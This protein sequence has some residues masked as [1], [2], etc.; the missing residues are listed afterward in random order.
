MGIFGK[1]RRPRSLGV[2]VGGEEQNFGVDT[3]F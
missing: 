1:L 3:P 2:G